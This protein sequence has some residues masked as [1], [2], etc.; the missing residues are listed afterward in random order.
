MHDSCTPAVPIYPH[1]SA[2]HNN[3]SE[4]FAG[5]SQNFKHKT[6]AHVSSSVRQLD[7][8]HNLSKKIQENLRSQQ[9]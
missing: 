1:S 9:R 2:T 3:M 8:R 7:D 6:S 4:V 5:T